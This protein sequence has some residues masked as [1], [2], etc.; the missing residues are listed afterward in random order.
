[1]TASFIELTLDRNGEKV[2]FN[3]NF[4][5]EVRSAPAKSKYRSILLFNNSEVAYVT[6][7]YEA[8]KAILT[9]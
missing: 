4:I 9:T 3:R 6:E 7:E 2:L 8:I 1:M 5:K